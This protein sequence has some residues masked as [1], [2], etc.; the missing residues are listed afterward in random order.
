MRKNPSKKWYSKPTFLKNDEN[1]YLINPD[2][3]D[4]YWYHGMFGELGVD[5][6]RDPKMSDTLYLTSSLEV[7]KTFAQLNNTEFFELNPNVNPLVYEVFVKLPSSMVFDIRKA[8]FDESYRKMAIEMFSNSPFGYYHPNHFKSV[9]SAMELLQFEMYD[10][11]FN[12]NERS[13]LLLKEYGFLGWLETEGDVRANYSKEF[14][15]SLA[16]LQEE[17]EDLI[18]VE[19]E[20][21]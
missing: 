6:I 1:G 15:L 12:E 18:F 10:N 13:R 5:S 17:T 16:L 8:V 19:L 7:A 2:T 11:N 14:P 3:N 20:D 9:Y 4:I 21:E